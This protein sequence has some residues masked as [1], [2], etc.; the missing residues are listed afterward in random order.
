MT[1]QKGSTAL[2]NP[3]NVKYWIIVLNKQNAKCDYCAT[4]LIRLLIFFFMFMLMQF[5]SSPVLK[6]DHTSTVVTTNRILLIKSIIFI[7]SLVFI[8]LQPH[9]KMILTYI[10]KNK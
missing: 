5:Y 7:F 10:T 1:L 4:R 6:C 8:F 9:V 2:A 3:R